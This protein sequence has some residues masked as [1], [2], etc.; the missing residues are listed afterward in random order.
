MCCVG[1]CAR[2]STSL[3]CLVSVNGGQEVRRLRAGRPVDGGVLCTG[4]CESL[5]MLLW[6]GDLR[7]EVVKGCGSDGTV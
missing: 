6:R 3:A 4:S 5:T 7:A 2:Q 1:V